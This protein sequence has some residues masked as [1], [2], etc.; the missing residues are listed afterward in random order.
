L[1]KYQSPG[2]DQIRAQLIQAG[3]EIIPFEIHKLVHSIW[4][5]EELPDKWKKSNIVPIYEKIE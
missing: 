3:G 4:N 2:C 5:K 1:K